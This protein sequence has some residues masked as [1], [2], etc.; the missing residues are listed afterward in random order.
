VLKK[1]ISS[2]KSEKYRESEIL[3]QGFL[4]HLT[5][6]EKIHLLGEIVEILQKEVRATHAQIKVVSA[7]ELSEKEKEAVANL[8]EGEIHQSGD[9]KFEVDPKIIGGLK[10][11]QGDS[12]IDLSTIGK[13]DILSSQI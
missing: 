4:D 1:N 3:A 7:V 11:F 2:S 12:V 6:T 9:I 10:I 8:F 5:N 13:L